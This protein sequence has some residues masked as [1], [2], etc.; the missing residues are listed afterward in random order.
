[1]L[2]RGHAMTLFEIWL[3]VALTGVSLILALLALLFGYNF[4]KSIQT[5]IYSRRLQKRLAE[6]GALQNEPEKTV[7]KL[8]LV[9][10]GKM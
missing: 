2:V 4:Y 10:G 6:L 5:A 8:K 9:A 1:M 7:G 3:Y